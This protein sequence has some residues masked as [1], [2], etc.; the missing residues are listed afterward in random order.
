[1]QEYNIVCH[2]LN[3]N[4]LVLSPTPKNMLP[5]NSKGK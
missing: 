3:I 4:I 1:M 2:Q 5:F